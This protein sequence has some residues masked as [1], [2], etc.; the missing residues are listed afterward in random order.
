MLA[1][2]HT[3]RVVLEIHFWSIPA[4]PHFFW[5]K[6]CLNETH[7][8]ILTLQILWLRQCRYCLSLIETSDT[9]ILIESPIAGDGW[10]NLLPAPKPPTFYSFTTTFRPTDLTFQCPAFTRRCSDDYWQHPTRYPRL[11]ATLFTSRPLF[12]RTKT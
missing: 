7:T 4:N 10:M 5:R 9:P 3:C 12:V 1:L 11:R 8:F 2:W 6:H